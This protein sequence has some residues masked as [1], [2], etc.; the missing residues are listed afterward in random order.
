M[1]TSLVNPIPFNIIS[2]NGSLFVLRSHKI[3]IFNLRC[4]SPEHCFNLSNE[5][6]WLLC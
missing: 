5:I 4:I 3:I 2:M 1:L 6:L